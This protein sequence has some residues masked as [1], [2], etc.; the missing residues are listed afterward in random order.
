MKCCFLTSSLRQIVFPLFS[1][2]RYPPYYVL[3]TWSENNF[4]KLFSDLL[5]RTQYGRYQILD[6]TTKTICLRLEVRKQHFKA[7][8]QLTLSQK[9]KS[10]ASKLTAWRLF[11][12]QNS[13]GQI[14]LIFLS[15]NL[16]TLGIYL[17]F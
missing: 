8:I 13:R 9:K 1:K 3:P 12:F 11:I 2:T 17:T 4:Q 16:K 5:G 15:Y 6:D 7:H 10:V 14:G